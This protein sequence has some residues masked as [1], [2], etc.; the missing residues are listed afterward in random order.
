MAKQIAYID[1]DGVLLTAKNT[2]PAPH[3]AAFIEFLVQHFDCYW[4]TTHCK[5]NSETALRYCRQYF[6]EATITLLQSFKPT[7]WDALKTE[8]IDFSADFL[9]LDD[10]P[11][12]AE[13]I[14]L[15]KHHAIDKLIVVKLNRDQELLQILE[16]LKATQV[17]QLST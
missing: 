17:S 1:I 6:E 15:Q 2:K 16:T 10:A 11:F 9:W 5:G 8:G 13:R 14:V 7:N 12:E 4:L 3:H